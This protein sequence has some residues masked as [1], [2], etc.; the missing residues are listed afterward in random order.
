LPFADSRRLEGSRHFH[1]SLSGVARDRIIAQSV[2][3]IPS[4]YES[5][6]LAAYEASRLGG[7]LVLN[8]SNLRSLATPL[9]RA[10]E[11]SQVRRDRPRSGDDAV[12]TLAA[13]ETT[14][15][16]RVDAPCARDPYWI[17]AQAPLAPDD[18]ERGLSCIVLVGDGL[19]DPAETLAALRAVRN[20]T[21][22]SSSCRSMASA[23]A[24]AT[25]ASM[26]FGPWRGE[27]G[28]RQVCRARF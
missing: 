16:A 19:G 15:L 5:Y 2:V 18:G 1:H 24:R 26:A 22:R 11:L 8:E 10:D 17:S 25:S 14:R 3:V 4:A 7:I 9:G 12:A 27:R 28:R 23:L 20:S 13:R 6:C 21:F